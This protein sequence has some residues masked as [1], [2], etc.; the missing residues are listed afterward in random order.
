MNYKLNKRTIILHIH[1]Q[2][3]VFIICIVLKWI[4]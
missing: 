1:K 2:Y 3:V 4:Y